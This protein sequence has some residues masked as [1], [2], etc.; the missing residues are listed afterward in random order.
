MST[1][2][3]VPAPSEPILIR[4]QSVSISIIP[5]IDKQ[6]VD[7][8]EVQDPRRINAMPSRGSVVTEAIKCLQAAGWA[9]GKKVRLVK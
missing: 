7:W 8:I 9:P 1:P 5:A 6:I 4:K 2:T 3:P